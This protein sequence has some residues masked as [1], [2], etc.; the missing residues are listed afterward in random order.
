MRLLVLRVVAVVS[1][2][3]A[4]VLAP[5]HSQAQNVTVVAKATSGLTFDPARDG[6][7]FANFANTPEIFS[8]S[9]AVMLRLCGDDACSFKSKANVCE[10]NPVL[11]DL[12]R[13]LN[14][15]VEVGHCVG[16]SA[17][18]QELFDGSAPRVAGLTAVSTSSLR[19]D[20]RNDG[21]GA[22]VDSTVRGQPMTDEDFK[23]AGKKITRTTI[24]KPQD[25]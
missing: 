12:Q 13:K 22:T 16:M 8:V 19:L 1:V 20:H 24:G 11:K 5:G 4:V 17:L 6:F 9:D 18:T 23:L 3:F 25:K 14:M 10:M 21:V 2:L 7:A 15:E